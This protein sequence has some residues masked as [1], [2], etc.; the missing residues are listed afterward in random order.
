MNNNFDWECGF[1]LWH[2]HTQQCKNEKQNK[3]TS[4]QVKSTK[5]DKVRTVFPI[6]LSRRR[7]EWAFHLTNEVHEVGLGWVAESFLLHF[8]RLPLFLLLVLLRVA[9][10][11][12]CS[13][14]PRT[15]GTTRLGSLSL[16]K[17]SKFMPF[18]SVCVY[19]NYRFSLSW[20]GLR[21]CVVLCSASTIWKG[22]GIN[23]WLLGNNVTK[24]SLMTILS[25][26]KTNSCVN[27]RFIMLTKFYLLN[28]RVILKVL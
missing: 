17:A 4:E 28:F 27:I 8:I 5:R 3:N 10:F 11:S 1:Y 14:F 7:P 6:F 13:I 23:P 25:E 2:T 18:F 15:A 24:R 21:C 26:K 9:Q 20:A 16:W 12:S 22:G 19:L